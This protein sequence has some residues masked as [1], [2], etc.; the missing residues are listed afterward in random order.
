MAH[1]IF[2]LP[3]KNKINSKPKLYD[4]ISKLEDLLMRKMVSYIKFGLTEFK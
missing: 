2:I 3:K 1:I 4:H